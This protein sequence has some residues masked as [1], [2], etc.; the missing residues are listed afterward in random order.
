MA[1]RLARDAHV[2]A[3]T[4][5]ELDIANQD[6]V[7]EAVRRQP[8]D[9]VINC[10]AYNMVDDAET[11][12]SEAMDVNAMGVLALARAAA[13]AGAVFVHYSTDFVFDGNID[14]PYTEDDRPAPLSTY[15]LSKLLGEWL[16]AE[17]G[18]HYVLRVESLFGG[19]RAKSSIDR[20]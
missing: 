5:A 3:L 1:A 18:R 10:S 15:G 20:I 2:V 8:V 9:V 11:R 14:R 16:S 13:S 6:A 7:L 4:R 17:A 19:T 12:A